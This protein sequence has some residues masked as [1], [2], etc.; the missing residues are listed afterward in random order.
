MS[1]SLADILSPFVGKIIFLVK[2][3]KHLEELKK[4]PFKPIAPISV[5]LKIIKEKLINE[6]TLIQ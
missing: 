3:S 6:K 2:N 1:C 4:V 5:A